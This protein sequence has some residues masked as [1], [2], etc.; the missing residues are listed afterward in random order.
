MIR[1]YA[2]SGGGVRLG[3]SFGAVLEGER[4]GRFQADQFDWYVGTS[5]GALDAVL[6]ANGWTGEQKKLL[7]LDTDFSRF[8]HPF[9]IP[10]GL[11]KFLAVVTPISLRKLGE[12][13]DSLQKPN[14][15]GPPL[16]QFDKLLINSVDAEEN[17][18]VVFCQ[19]RP[20]WLKSSKRLRIEPLLSKKQTLG[21]VITRSMVLPGLRADDLRWQDGG[22]AENPLLSPLPKDADITLIHL[23]Y[24]GLV[25]K[26]GSTSP[27][28]ALEQA[29]YD[30]EFKAYSFAEHLMSAFSNLTVIRPE[31]YDVE[32]ANF[33]LSRDEKQ[34]MLLRAMVNTQTQWAT[35]AESA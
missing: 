22:V 32:S 29:L 11:R 3:A 35:L 20:E 13:I 23:G 10:M 5:A 31:I 27:K 2:S 18:H 4:Q 33:A 15:Y 8:F 25:W 26:Q 28:N 24:A 9:L 30:Y 7:F 6:T 21:M 16:Q 17:M 1:I 19:E 34:D 12:F 14:P